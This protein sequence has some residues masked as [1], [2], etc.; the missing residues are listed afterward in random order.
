MKSDL[1]KADLEFR[2]EVIDK[3]LGSVDCGKTMKD[4]FGQFL[5]N[6]TADANHKH[7]AYHL[8]CIVTLYISK[9][10]TLDEEQMSILCRIVEQMRQEWSGSNASSENSTAPLYTEEED[11]FSEQPVSSSVAT[12]P[13]TQAGGAMAIVSKDVLTGDANNVSE[14]LHRLSISRSPTPDS[15]VRGTGKCTVAVSNFH[16]GIGS[17]VKEE[18][19]KSQYPFGYRLMTKQGWAAESGLGPYGSG[20]PRPLDAHV[21]TLG[22]R[23]HESPTGLG[24]A[25]NASTKLPVDEDCTAEAERQ[26]DG[27]VGI[28]TKK[29]HRYVED[30]RAGDETAKSS[31]TYNTAIKAPQGTGVGHGKTTKTNGNIKTIV[32]GECVIKDKWK[33]TSNYTSASQAQET[34]PGGLWG[35]YCRKQQKAPS[36]DPSIFVACRNNFQGW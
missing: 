27:P 15:F 18:D 21:L 35:I 5:R 28:S 31:Y 1:R 23:D 26:M 20:I 33:D 25:P 32:Q 29:W 12:L 13:H 4:S 22:L 17:K 8:F 14:A 30:P 9:Q 16:K 24:Y 2:N 34:V 11:V 6:I 7:L 3:L 36:G 10:T 19:L